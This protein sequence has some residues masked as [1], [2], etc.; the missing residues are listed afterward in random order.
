MD[1]RACAFIIFVKTFY[2]T[3]KLIKEICIQ[4]VRQFPDKTYWPCMT[5]PGMWL[6]SA[7]CASSGRSARFHCPWTS[8]NQ[9]FWSAFYRSKTVWHWHLDHMHCLETQEKGIWSASHT[10]QKKTSESS[11]FQHWISSGATIRF[12]KYGHTLLITHLRKDSNK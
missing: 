6:T 4:K 12:V 3:V 11:H 8:D 1:F 10:P 5:V 2:R 7:S 9:H